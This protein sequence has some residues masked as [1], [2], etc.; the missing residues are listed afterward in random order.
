M[1]KLTREEKIKR[2]KYRIKVMKAHFYGEAVEY[3]TGNRY[4]LITKRF[5]SW[6]W[7]WTDYRISED[8]EIIPSKNEIK[9]KDG[10]HIALVVEKDNED[11]EMHNWLIFSKREN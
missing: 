10:K 8:P 1:E 6:N 9:T 7:K 5:C 11:L 3:S 4:C 2:A